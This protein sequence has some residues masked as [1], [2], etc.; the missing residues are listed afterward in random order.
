MNLS[1]F[2]NTDRQPF[3]VV[4]VLQ[5]NQAFWFKWRGREQID[6]FKEV[7]V[8][9]DDGG[10]STCPWIDVGGTDKLE[11]NAELMVELVLDT[12]LDELDRV[13]LDQQSSIVMHR[14][15]KKALVR[16]LRLDFPYA[17]V[18][19]LP[20]YFQSDCASILHH[21]IR[22]DWASWLG[23][24][25]QQAVSITHVVTSTELFC[26]WSGVMG[27][28][29]LMVQHSDAETRHLLLDGDIPIYM[30][31]VP[32]E[33]ASSSVA[34]T[35][36][37]ATLI[38]QS[39]IH[40]AESVLPDGKVPEVVSLSLTDAG[41][42]NEYTTPRLL[43]LLYLN[44]A[45]DIRVGKHDSEKLVNGQAT[46]AVLS[47]VSSKRNGVLRESKFPGFSVLLHRLT[48]SQSK[49][50]WRLT[51]RKLMAGQV[52]KPSLDNYQL[53]KK[54]ARLQQA[55]LLCAVMAVMVLT[56]AS[57]H[58]IASSRERRQLA[59]EEKRLVSS[60]DSLSLSVSDIH[61]T[62]AFVSDSLMRINSHQTINPE[63][64]LLLV[65]EVITQFPFISL[66]SLSWAVLEGEHV[67]DSAFTTATSVSNRRQLWSRE[68]SGELTQLELGGTV[69]GPGGVREKQQVVDSLIAH[70][71]GLTGVRLVS[72]MESP[73]E[74]ARSS[75]D[76]RGGLSKYRLSIVFGES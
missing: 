72:V 40:C 43:S 33:D 65:A 19:T 26:R 16:K 41:Q 73:I 45:H 67:L 46:C 22:D 4:L 49:D 23:Q 11:Q 31:I 20:N 12:T 17:S 68:S 1:G 48:N 39:L 8:L 64:L 56:L 15:Q 13:K 28:L 52:L 3:R 74:S 63:T 9:D 42:F 60:V 54:I 59:D 25:Q 18:N 47:E 2:I 21:V 34:A 35:S 76:I 66:D 51:R 69:D 29:R 75:A 14:Y 62:P 27:G 32:C 55:T 5:G 50:P 57:V 37:S 30:R 38:G 7:L 6:F 10:F 58:G 44:Q 24:L 36:S 61:M 70:L 71:Q 53:R